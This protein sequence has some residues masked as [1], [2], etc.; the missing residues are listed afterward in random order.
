MSVQ[1][2]L[3]QDVSEVA[4]LLAKEAV[5][6]D[7]VKE[8]DLPTSLR[9]FGSQAMNYASDAG[10]RLGEF[11]ANFGNKAQEYGN[12]ALEW[13]NEPGS[14]GLRY[15][16]AGAGVGG[17]LGLGSQFNKDP[18]ER[19][20]GSSA[21]SGALAG[22]ALGGG[23]GLIRQHGGGLYG[24]QSKGS[25]AAEP[26]AD[27]AGEPDISQQ[28]E[29]I[30][31]QLTEHQQAQAAQTSQNYGDAA[32]Q[33]AGMAGA[34][35]GTHQFLHNRPSQLLRRGAG[36]AEL[37][38]YDPAAQA[39]IKKMRT[40][41]GAVP[42]NRSWLSSYIDPQ[43]PHHSTTF[44]TVPD[45]D[46]PLGKMLEETGAPLSDGM[47]GTKG[48]PKTKFN[49]GRFLAPAEEANR[50]IPQLTNAQVRQLGGLHNAKLPG[51]VTGM[52]MA[53]L[54]LLPLALQ[55]FGQQSANQQQQDFAQGLS[56]GSN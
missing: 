41:P 17:L 16:L 6:R 30:N 48:V 40:A 11:G 8:A 43:L 10:K 23:M 50:H 47:E 56:G 3:E 15:G 25:P 55:Y 33:G 18:E 7:L 44:E 19:Q 28:I 1:S 24:P 34:T 32:R 38:D 45:L 4:D 29:E 13:L 52:G 20:F 39:A 31:K 42:L 51:R 27:A 49:W 36:A 26:G 14:E 12:Q 5:A 22:G 37:D 9:D 21:I 54:G 46:N 2:W 35:L 53:G